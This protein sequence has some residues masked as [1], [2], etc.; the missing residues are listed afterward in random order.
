MNR[1]AMSAASLKD[2]SGRRTQEEENRYPSVESELSWL[3]HK[4]EIGAVLLCHVLTYYI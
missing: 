4:E 3:I 2:F 1:S